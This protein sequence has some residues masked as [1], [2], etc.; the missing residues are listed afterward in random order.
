MKITIS[1]S[2]GNIGIHLTKL[3]VAAGHQVTVITSRADRAPAI[4]ALGAQAA[5][6]SVSDPAFLRTAIAGADGLFAMTPPNLGG[7]DVLAN[8]AA[9]GIA[10]AEAI[11]ATGV[12]RVVMLSSVGADLPAG[13]GPIAGLH[14]IEKAYSALEGV[15]VTFLRAGYFFTNFY[16]DVPLIQ[17]A[18]IMGGNFPA[19]LRLALVHPAD[20]AAAAAHEL[21]RPGDGKEIKYVV[22]DVRTPQEVASVVGKAIGKPGLPWVEFTDEQALQG[23]TQAGVPAEIAGLYAEMGTG[24]RSGKLLG[25][26]E[27]SGSPVIGKIRLE[28]FAQEFAGRF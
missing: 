24:F 4:E 1:G 6:G 10:F 22:S 25:H 12:K 19:T 28:E 7:Q 23:M 20:I 2:L 15:S 26:F 21:Q 5:V 18:G 9:A 16:N 3:L 17:G 14:P 27:E 11:R 8:T 13:N